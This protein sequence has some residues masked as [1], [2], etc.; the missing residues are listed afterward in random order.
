MYLHQG[1]GKN[2]ILTCVLGGIKGNQISTGNETILQSNLDK[3]NNSQ[4]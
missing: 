1:W 3:T 2:I 4:C